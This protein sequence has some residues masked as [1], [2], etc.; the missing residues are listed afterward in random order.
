[1]V[2]KVNAIA[3]SRLVYKTNYDTKINE[4]KGK[5]PSF[6]GLA[7]TDVLNMA[8]NEITH[9]YDLVKETDCDA[10]ISGIEGNIPPHLII[11]NL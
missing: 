7:T 4:I 10:K 1:M 2:K 3:T 9:V 8:E 11:I 6:T 5:I